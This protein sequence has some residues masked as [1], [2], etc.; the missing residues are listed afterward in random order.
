MQKINAQDVLL[1]TRNNAFR[2]WN[3]STSSSIL[4]VRPDDAACRINSQNGL[5]VC[6]A[7]P[8]PNLFL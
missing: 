7:T 1:H 2:F 6:C 3:Q 4:S 5:A 8:P